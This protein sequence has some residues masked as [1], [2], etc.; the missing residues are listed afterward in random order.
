MP[1]ALRTN[2]TQLGPHPVD[3]PSKPVSTVTDQPKQPV[4]REENIPLKRST[5]WT[6]LPSPDE[7]RLPPHEGPD[8]GHNLAVVDSVGA[9][10]LVR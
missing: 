5:M 3:K 4:S 10:L 8:L 2:L 9:D 6:D 1:T 7:I